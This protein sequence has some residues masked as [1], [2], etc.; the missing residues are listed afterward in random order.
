MTAIAVLAM[1]F[2][3]GA[4]L[5]ESSPGSDAASSYIKGDTDLVKTGG[6]LTFQ[7]IYYES[8]EFDTLTIT[9]TAALN[10]SSGSA[11]S[12]AVSPS[13][14]TLT[15]GTEK[16]LT[17]TAPSA[18]GKYTL[19]VNFKAAKDGGTAV[20][21]QKTQTIT[22]VNPI[23]LS[24]TLLNNSRVNFTDF[25]VYFKVDGTLIDDSKTLVSVGAGETT[26][27]SFQWVTGA[28]SN[29]AHT[30]QL[31]AGDENI[32][33]A[34]ASFVG[35]K[36]TFYIGHSDYGLFNILLGILLVFLVI[37]LIYFYR[38]PVKNYGKPK[39]RR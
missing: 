26:T 17:I 28:L 31:V 34:N 22:V 27:V 24:A 29:G 19:E 2:A 37:L 1:L 15:N 20:Q 13:S 35:S 6:T 39:S 36:G 23:V 12:G 7:I 16:A 4:V 38:K 11:Q 14:G 25:A 10:D 5:I 18:P 21:T 3:V 9:Y 30:F 8:E 32:G 33:S